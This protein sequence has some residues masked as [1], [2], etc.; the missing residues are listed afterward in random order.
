VRELEEVTPWECKGGSKEGIYAWIFILV[1][2]V[3]VK[4]EILVARYYLMVSILAS[5]EE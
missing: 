1:E 5:M 4:D 2:I 3:L